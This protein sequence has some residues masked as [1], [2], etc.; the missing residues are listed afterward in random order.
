MAFNTDVIDDDPTDGAEDLPVYDTLVHELGHLLGLSHPPENDK[1]VACTLMAGCAG[2]I[3]KN[4]LYDPSCTCDFLTIT[5]LDRLAVQQ[6][7][8]K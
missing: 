1:S 3:R 5:E 4:P 6:I 7:Y 2:A 8:E